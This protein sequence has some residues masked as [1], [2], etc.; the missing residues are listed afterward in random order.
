LDVNEKPKDLPNGRQTITTPEC[1]VIPLAIRHG[2]PYMDMYP[3]SDEEMDTLPHVTFTSDVPW[4]PTIYDNEIDSFLEDEVPP[5]L[6]R[7][8]HHYDSDD[9]T[10]EAAN[11][12][13]LTEDW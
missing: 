10:I 6:A 9:D 5:L 8:P 1:Y 13:L 2:L 11:P 4:D 3:P 7:P 12:S